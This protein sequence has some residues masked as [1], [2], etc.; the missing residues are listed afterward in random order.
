MKSHVC[1]VYTSPL[2]EVPPCEVPRPYEVLLVKSLAIMMSWR[3]RPLMKSFSGL[4]VKSPPCM[5]F[6]QGDCKG[7]MQCLCGVHIACGFG[8]LQFDACVM[9]V[10][11]CLPRLVSRAV[12]LASGAAQATSFV[13]NDGQAESRVAVQAAR[14]D[15]SR[16]RQGSQ[17][18]RG[19]KQGHS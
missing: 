9:Y 1:P 19:R 4:P 5:M 7:L 18:S 3:P 17:S 8:M 14:E 10:M 12:R 2:Y 15:G 11:R 16:R 13:C 6:V